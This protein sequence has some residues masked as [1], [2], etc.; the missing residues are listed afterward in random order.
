MVRY[1]P[2][3]FSFLVFLVFWML[4]QI[5]D[6]IHTIFLSWKELWSQNWKSKDSLMLLGRQA[7]HKD[8]YIY[9]YSLCYRHYWHATN[10]VAGKI[11]VYYENKDLFLKK[12]LIDART[13]FENCVDTLGTSRNKASKPNISYRT[14]KH[15]LQQRKQEISLLFL[16]LTIPVIQQGYVYEGPWLWHKRSLHTVSAW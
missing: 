7:D 8:F 16:L 12:K 13:K 11:Q 2:H 9:I 15:L 6:L 14:W 1:A 10:K 4:V 3:F 5:S